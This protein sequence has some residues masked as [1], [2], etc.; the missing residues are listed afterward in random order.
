MCEEDDIDQS[1]LN[2]YDRWAF[3]LKKG[4]D[5]SAGQSFASEQWQ[6]YYVDNSQTEIKQQIYYTKSEIEDHARILASGAYRNQA[7]AML[8]EDIEEWGEPLVFQV[9]DL[10]SMGCKLQRPKVASQDR[11]LVYEIFYRLKLTCDGANVSVSLQIAQPHSVHYSGTF[12][13]S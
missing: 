5:V 3:L 2:V 7:N 4:D 10:R 9:P 1:V 8:R 13:C 11:E 6:Q 12:S